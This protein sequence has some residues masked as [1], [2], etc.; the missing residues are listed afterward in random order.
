MLHSWDSLDNVH[1]ETLMKFIKGPDF[2]TGGIVLLEG[3]ENQLLA[4]YA[5]GKGPGCIA[6]QRSQGGNDPRTIPFDHH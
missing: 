6:G 2:P 1:I 5:T 4:A 3:E